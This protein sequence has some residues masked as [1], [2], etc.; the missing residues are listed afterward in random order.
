MQKKLTKLEPSIKNLDSDAYLSLIPGLYIGIKMKS[1]NV[2]FDG[3]F[4]EQILAYSVEQLQAHLYN[5][6]SY[7]NGKIVNWKHF[8]LNDIEHNSRI[9]AKTPVLGGKGGFGSLLRAFGKQILISNNKEACRDLNGRRM[10]DVNN[11]KKLK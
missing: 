9:L 4:T 11:E 10:R 1:I 7:L 2:C 5:Y 8:N 6:T 3:R